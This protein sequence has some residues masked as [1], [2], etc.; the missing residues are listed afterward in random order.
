MKVRFNRTPLVHA[1]VI[2]Q[3]PQELVKN[4]PSLWQADLDTAAR[5]GGDLT[6]AALGAMRLRGDKKHIVVDTKVHMLMPGQCPAIPGW[7]TDGA[8]R[9]VKDRFMLAAGSAEPTEVEQWTGDYS[10]TGQGPPDLAIQERWDAGGGAPRFHLL[11]TGEG[12]LTE[13][14]TEEV[15]I[16]VPDEP[17]SDLYKAATRAVEAAHFDVRLPRH[18][19]LSE[20]LWGP[21]TRS[22]G[23]VREF[24]PSCTAVEWD[25]WNLHQGTIATKREWRY[26]IR[27]TE[28][29]HHEPLP[30]SRLPEII[31]TQQMVYT[32]AEFGW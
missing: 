30:A 11:V 8:P 22:Y 13:F 17:S 10:P 12:C 20:G 31:R 5:Y 2:E 27:V 15:L 18:Q 4:T 25:W 23:S 21:Y 14:L 1:G 28:S 9:A 24:A 29:D 19:G 16:D 32:P 6:R 26:L 7:H 3:P